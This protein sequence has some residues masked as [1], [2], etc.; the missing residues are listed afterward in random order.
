LLKFEFT[1][2]AKIPILQAKE[3]FSMLFLLYKIK[4]L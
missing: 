2:A 1:L 3:T 4:D